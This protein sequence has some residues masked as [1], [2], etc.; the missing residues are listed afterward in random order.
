[1]PPT[2]KALASGSDHRAILN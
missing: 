1:M 2:A